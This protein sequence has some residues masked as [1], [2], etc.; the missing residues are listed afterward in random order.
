MHRSGT[1]VL[2]GCL[3]LLGVNLGQS[4]M[5]PTPD[6]P[7]GYWENNDIVSV[8]DILFRELSHKWDRIGTLPE[9][10]LATD[11]AAKAKQSIKNLINAHY[12]DKGLWAVKDPR[13]CRLMPLWQEVLDDMGINPGF[14]VT[15]R[16]PLE[17]AGSLSR[18][19]KFSLRKGLLLWLVHNRDIFKACQGK[20]C[21]MLT[22]DQLLADPISTLQKIETDLSISFPRPVQQAYPDILNFIQP[23]LRT[24]HL[25]GLSQ[26]DINKYSHFS[27]IYDQIRMM[28]TPSPVEAEFVFDDLLAQISE[29]EREW[30]SKETA[31]ERHLL[32]KDIHQAMAAQVFFPREQD[33]K[34]AEERSKT[35]MLMPEQWQEVVCEIPDPAVL[36]KAGLRFDPL[37]TNGIVCISSISLVDLATGKVLFQADKENGFDDLIVPRHGL[38]MPDPE[39]L[40]LFVSGFDPQIYLPALAC[41]HDCPMELRVWIKVSRDQERV[42]LD[43]EHKITPENQK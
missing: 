4:M 21:T 13:M 6:N 20:P 16:H 9:D 23:G 7:A 35:F 15:V 10:W 28:K 39:N 27:E 8:H 12:T 1:S 42:R 41:S 2:T 31:K 40:V 34:Y 25:G 17:T 43:L 33:P 36:A 5:P 14:V 37:N 22:Y 26:E 32:S 18:R 29:L 30:F 3:N 38:R 24:Q 11:A 19:D